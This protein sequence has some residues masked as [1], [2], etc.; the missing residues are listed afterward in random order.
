MNRSAVRMQGSLGALASLLLA[1]ACAT[2]AHRRGGDTVDQWPEDSGSRS[3]GVTSTD[4]QRRAPAASA[5]S[6]RALLERAVSPTQR[7]TIAEAE[8]GKAI[9]AGRG[10]DAAFILVELLRGE[11][12]PT[13]KTTQVQRLMEVADSELS[14]LEV[15]TLLEADGL[16]RE[17]KEPLTFKVALLTL[18]RGELD[19]GRGLLQAY[20]QNYP[21]G[22]YAARA[23]ARLERL[24]AQAR[25]APTTVGVLLPLSGTK[26]AYGRLARQAIEL[27]MD[28]SKIRL[29]VE[30]TKDDENTTMRAVEKLVLEHGAIAILGPSFSDPSRAAGVVAQR[31]GVPLLSISVAEDL[32]GFGPWVFRNGFTD[33]AQAEALAEHA[34]KVLGHRR[35]AILHPRHPYGEGLRDLFWAAIRARGGE[36]TGIESYEVDAT[37]FS[38]PVKRLV[39]RFEP[40]RRSD[41]R[42]AR[43]DCDK[44][45]D[46]YRRQRCRE[47]VAKDIAPR[48]E[49]DAL[50]IPDYARNVRM[51]AAALAV[52]DVIVEQDPRR[53]RIIQKSLGREPDVVT[54]L[55]PNGWNSPKITESTGRTVENAVF[56]DGFFP[57]ADDERTAR[58]V[59]AY[60]ERFGGRSPRLF[61]EALMYDSARI[62]RSLIETRQPKTRAAFREAL[63]GVRAFPGVTGD[64]SFD[65]KTDARKTLRVLTIKDGAIKV[66]P[67]V[68]PVPAGAG[69]G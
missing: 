55:G 18:H 5:D 49:F 66:V 11:T 36:V 16:P 53:L 54:L 13:Q 3:T 34:V 29:V 63:L 32:P 57:E 7:R 50:F 19:A 10:L 39:G 14:P 23:R 17:T 33:R 59:R 68:P 20:L 2:P 6:A 22:P 28:G 26:A 69:P 47:G 1:V 4:A 52:E 12:D 65:G 31:L 67:P 38:N 60:Q 24:D 25:V 37:T 8:V 44:E 30:D 58:F 41:Y 56:V 51:I 43:E 9:E 27:A 21:S 46:A 15:R 45:R 61:P 40:H 35:F 42:A 62:L 48:V 64:T